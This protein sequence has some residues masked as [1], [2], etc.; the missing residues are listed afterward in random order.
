[1]KSHVYCGFP[2][3]KVYRDRDEVN[4]TQR[5]NTINMQLLVRIKNKM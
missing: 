2:F 3:F 1:M 5:E 4:T